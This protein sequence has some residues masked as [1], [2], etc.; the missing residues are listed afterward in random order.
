MVQR[1]VL[2]DIGF[3]A[4]DVAQ[5]LRPDHLVRGAFVDDRAVAHR[6]DVVADAGR[7][8]DVVQHHHDG[9]PFLAVEPLDEVD[10]FELVGD[11]E[12]GRRFVE[13]QQRSLLG[14]RHRDPG[15]LPLAAGELIDRAV[16]QVLH[17][18][19]VEGVVDRYLVGLRWAAA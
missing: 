1:G 11:V 7:F 10:D 19:Q 18:G 2:V 9:A 3:D 14:E 13:Q 15:A 16:A 12:K 6:H 4:I 5:H 17:A 8:I